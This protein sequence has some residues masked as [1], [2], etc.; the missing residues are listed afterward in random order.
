LTIEKLDC[1]PKPVLGL[2]EGK[3]R[4]KAMTTRV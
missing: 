3:N 4:E 1:A 2:A